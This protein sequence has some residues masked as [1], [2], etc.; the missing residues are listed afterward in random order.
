MVVY[1]G[2]DDAD[3]AGAVVAVVAEAVFEAG[4]TAAGVAERDTEPAAGVLRS[5]ARIVAGTR[6]SAGMD[7]TRAGR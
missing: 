4:K 6:L 1:D 3:V 2:G 7:Y 5:E